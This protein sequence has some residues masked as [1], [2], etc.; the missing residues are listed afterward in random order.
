MQ[1]LF[2]KNEDGKE[3]FGLLAYLESIDYIV[4][5]QVTADQVVKSIFFV[6]KDAI[7]DARRWPEAIIIDAT[8]KTNAHKLSLINIVGTSNVSSIKN[9]NCFQTFA[10][11][12]AFVNSET[13]AGYTWVLGELREAIWPSG[14]KH[15]LPSIFVTD[16]ERALRNAIQII[17][18]ES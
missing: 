3:L 4:R 7:K 16:N 10:I 6:H 5:I 8:Y 2:L 17:F 9:S 11:A 1:S 14:W 18:P 12:A 15:R 13:E